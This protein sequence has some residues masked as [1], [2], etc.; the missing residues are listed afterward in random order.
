MRDLPAIRFSALRYRQKRRDKPLHI[1][2]NDAVRCQREAQKECGIVE[3]LKSG[4]DA[5]KVKAAD[6][7]VRATVEATLADIEKRGN[8]AIREM[9]VK[10]DN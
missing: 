4:A 6:E 3:I 10:F 1:V 8:A 7:M 2:F 5:S 9:S